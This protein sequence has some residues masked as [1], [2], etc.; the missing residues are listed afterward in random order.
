MNARS[1]PHIQRSDLMGDTL[2]SV[3]PWAKQE[4]D[5]DQDFSL[6]DNIYRQEMNRQHNF[7]SRN[8]QLGARNNN[9]NVPKTV[10]QISKNDDI[11]Q[12][13]KPITNVWKVTDTFRNTI[14]SRF[15]KNNLTDD[16]EDILPHCGQA[17]TPRLTH[18]RIS[19]CQRKRQNQTA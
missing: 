17:L 4:T 8:L 11:C 3:L 15:P 18:H 14:N 16:Q 9:N 2:T 7:V 19:V 13:W 10:S 6:L 12:E 5:L 1:V